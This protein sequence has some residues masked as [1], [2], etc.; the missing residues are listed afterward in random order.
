MSSEEL[1]S[2]PLELHDHSQS[3]RASLDVSRASLRFS[4]CLND[5]PTTDTSKAGLLLDGTARAHAHHRQQYRLLVHRRAGAASAGAS[6]TAAASL[7]FVARVRAHMTRDHVPAARRVRTLWALV[8]LL[9]G[10]RPL[11][12]GEMVRA[13]EDL[14]THF[15]RVRLDTRVQTH[16]ARQHVGS[17]ERSLAH[18]AHVGFGDVGCPGAALVPGGHVFREP[19]L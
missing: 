12:G 7:R 15:A 14:A 2:T 16:V 4:L 17:G 6:S 18:L 9:A 5:E 8:G 11:M 13:G 10:V 19:V 1:A 3:K